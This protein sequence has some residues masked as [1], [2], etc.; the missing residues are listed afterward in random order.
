MRLSH[1]PLIF[2][3]LLILEEAALT[4]QERP[5]QISAGIRLALAYLFAISR[6]GRDV[7]DYFPEAIS[8]E[9]RPDEAAW[10]PGYFRNRDA[11][12]SIQTIIRSVGFNPT[13]EILS[14]LRDA[15]GDG[16]VAM[17][18]KRFWREV[19]QQAE[20]GTRHPW[21]GCEWLTPRGDRPGVS[22]GVSSKR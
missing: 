18:S 1:R 11:N 8:R 19:D 12:A 2:R 16:D 10:Q 4:S 17:Q 22:A 9:R 5:L 3:A 14:A 13:V 7:F 21:P 6:E 20:T 15:L